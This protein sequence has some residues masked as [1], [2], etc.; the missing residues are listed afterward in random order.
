LKLGIIRK[1]TENMM[2]KAAQDGRWGRG[3][4]AAIQHCPRPGLQ[5][6]DLQAGFSRH[7]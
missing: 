1:E 4:K 6:G 7:G 3:V 5:Q 2:E